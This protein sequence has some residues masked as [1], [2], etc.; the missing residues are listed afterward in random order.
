MDGMN[1]IYILHVEG[2]TEAHADSVVKNEKKTTL[3]VSLPLCIHHG[4]GVGTLG[5]GLGL[6]HGLM[7]VTLHYDFFDEKLLRTLL[8]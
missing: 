2:K 6:G 3:V 5:H 8:I 4:L 1:L 7:Q